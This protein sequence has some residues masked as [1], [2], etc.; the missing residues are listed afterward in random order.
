MGITSFY[1][2]KNL[3]CFGDGGAI[4]TQNK[5]LANKIRLLA[6]HGQDQK[7]THSIIGLNS[8]LDSLQAAILSFKLGL[9]DEF[10]LE[11]KKVASTIKFQYSKI[12]CLM[13]IQ[14]Y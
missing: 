9:L 12:S 13:K 1:P 7:Y 10:N 14:K 6:N 11:R 2:S 3:G 5:N 4:F 8:R